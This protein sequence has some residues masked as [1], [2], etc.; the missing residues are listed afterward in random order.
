MIKTFLKGNK[1]MYP[2]STKRKEKQ[3]QKKSKI[4][5]VRGLSTLDRRG[6]RNLL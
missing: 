3:Q 4:K 6:A 5:K 1:S 2:L